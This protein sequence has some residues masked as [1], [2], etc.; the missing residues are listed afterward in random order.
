MRQGRVLSPRSASQQS[1]G[2][3]EQLVIA[4]VTNG[5][6]HCCDEREIGYPEK[7][8]SVC[9]SWD[10]TAV[11]RGG[12]RLESKVVFSDDYLVR[13]A[14][15][16]ERRNAVHFELIATPDRALGHRNRGLH[17]DT[18]SLSQVRI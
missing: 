6:F 12:P 11:V 3:E 13:W 4:A 14:K 17:P 8:A 18:L 9:A 1:K 7:L 2:D 16:L 15:G 5:F 10:I